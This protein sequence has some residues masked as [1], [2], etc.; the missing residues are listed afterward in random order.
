MIKGDPP[1]RSTFPITLWWPPPRCLLIVWVLGR[2]VS[3]PPLYVIYSELNRHGISRKRE[4]ADGSLTRRRS[5]P[6]VLYVRHPVRSKRSSGAAPRAARKRK[7]EIGRR[8]QYASRPFGT[9]DC[10]VTRYV[11][12]YMA[13]HLTGFVYK[14]AARS[15]TSAKRTPALTAPDCWSRRCTWILTLRCMHLRC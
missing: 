13:P 2:V 5:G 4:N 6:T 14:L 3:L 15:A 10:E 8:S 11:D 1:P 9:H 12:A 7:H